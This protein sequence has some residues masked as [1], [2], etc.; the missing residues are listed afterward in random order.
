MESSSWK[1][2]QM[3]QESFLLERRNQDSSELEEAY[4][5]VLIN[6]LFISSHDVGW[7]LSFIQGMDDRDL[8]GDNQLENVFKSFSKNHTT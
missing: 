8:F 4:M 5:S 7:T 6:Y 1:Y 3:E 2:L